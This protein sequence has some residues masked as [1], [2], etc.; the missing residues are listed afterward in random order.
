M[1]NHDTY[2][3]TLGNFEYGVFKIG[4]EMVGP[5]EYKVSTSGFVPP[6][7]D[8]E[9]KIYTDLP[10]AQKAFHRLIR[11]AINRATEL[12]VIYNSDQRAISV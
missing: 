9:T 3:R 1:L 2:P 11:V 8:P 10:L 12:M 4:F 7:A 5:N 6:I